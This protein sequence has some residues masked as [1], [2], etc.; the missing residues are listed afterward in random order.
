LSSSRK[1]EKRRR[2]ALARKDARGRVHLVLHRDGAGNEVVAL[3]RPVFQEAWQNEL[4]AGT[5]NTARALLRDEPTLESTR[6][7]AR[8]AMAATSRLADGL[9]AQ[10]PPGS[11]ACG[12]GCDHCCYQVVGVTPAEAFAV[13]EHV[14][15]TRSADAVSELRARA[16]ELLDQAGELDSNARFSPEHPCLF[17]EVATGRCTIY[18]ARPLACRGMNS[19]DADECAKRLRDPE[20]RAAFLT[21]GFG[22]H[23]YLEPI[24]AFHA[25]SAGLQ[26]TLAELYELDMRPLELLKAVHLLLSGDEAAI[27]GARLAGETPLAL[28]RAGDQSEEPGMRVA[29]GALAFAG[30]PGDTSAHDQDLKRRP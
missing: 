14:R 18:E 10:A 28:A 4:T 22:G 15:R 25:I 6:Q 9:L 16:A 8:Q 13:V 5:A 12:A 30:K 21:Q 27:A 17:L 7:L 19:L 23:S 26:L 24:R 29:S 1:K 2:R 11:V 3:A 20:S